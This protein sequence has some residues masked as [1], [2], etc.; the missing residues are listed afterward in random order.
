MKPSE[1]A[2]PAEG[3]KPSESAKPAEGV[4][5]SE[6][7]KPA[8]GVKPSESAKPADGAM[9]AVP[10]KQTVS[11][12]NNQ[13]VISDHQGI[14]N[15]NQ[16]V[17]NIPGRGLQRH[18]LTLTLCF[19]IENTGLN[20]YKLK[21]TFPSAVSAKIRLEVPLP[22][23]QFTTSQGVMAM[24]PVMLNEK[25]SEIT[26]NG[27]NRT[28]DPTEIIWSKKENKVSENKVVMQVEDAEIGVTPSLQ[29]AQF[30]VV[31]PVKISGGEMDTFRI[32]LPKNTQL[33]R[34]SL[35]ATG[36][37]NNVLDIRSITEKNE[38]EVKEAVNSNTINNNVVNKET[39]KTESTVPVLNI[40]TPDKGNEK[41][42]NDT[43]SIIEIHLAQKVTEPISFRF[44]AVARSPHLNIEEGKNQSFPNWELSGFEL[45]EAQKQYGRIKF[46]FPKG[47]GFKVSPLFGVRMIGIEHGDQDNDVE[48]YQF[49][50]QPFAMNI[51]VIVQQ[52]R[53][54][55]K[56]EYQIQVQQDEVRL[57]ALFR[58]TIYGSKVREL[59][60][61]IDDW[62]ISEVK[63]NYIV[64]FEKIHEE[65]IRRELI[66]PL[67]V[68]SEGQLELELF[69]V[70]K[71]QGAQKTLEFPMPVPL[72]DWIEP[73]A[74]VIVPDDNIELLPDMTKTKGIRLTSL[75]SLSIV[76]ELPSRQQQPLSFIMENRDNRKD[77]FKN[78]EFEFPM[79]ASAV[80]YHERSIE[81]KSR[82]D[83]FL[84]EKDTDKIQQT[85]TYS[86]L[87]E[88]LEA[89][90]LSIP[91]ELQEPSA[92]KVLVDGKP[93]APQN[94]V[95]DINDDPSAK[96]VRKKILLNDQPR[97]GDCVVTLLYSCRYFE[98]LPQMTNKII[99]D[100]V[101]PLDGKLLSNQVSVIAPSGINIELGAEEDKQWTF[102]EA[103]SILKGEKL[104]YYYNTDKISN[105]ITLKGIINA[106]DV[107]GSTLVEKAWIQTWLVN[108]TRMD[109]SSYRILSDQKVITLKLPPKVRKERISLLFNS[110]SSYL[111]QNLD[112][113][114]DRF[115]TATLNT[116]GEL[117]IPI[118]EEYRMKPFTLDISWLIDLEPND[119]LYDMEFPY[120]TGSSIW[121]RRTYWQV[122]LPTNKHLV[123]NMAGWT[124]EYFNKLFWSGFYWKREA[125]MNQEELASWVGVDQRESI[126]DGTNTYLFSSFRAPQN[127]ML[128]IMDRSLL[129]LIGSGLALLIGLSFIYLPLVRH[130]GIVL[131]FIIA[132]TALCSYQPSD[133][134][135]Y[136]QTSVFGIILALLT[137]LLMRIFGGA[138]T[139]VWKPVRMTEHIEYNSSLN[140]TTDK[141]NSQVKKSS[142]IEV[143]K[144]DNS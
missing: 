59:A 131:L 40:K 15:H 119:N 63:S 126:P 106:R 45:L 72:A 104:T 11:I 9:P 83:V 133:S 121:I 87:F 89:I 85:L 81:V 61:K 23:I 2:K 75:R 142:I 90:Q 76:M 116:K 139:P 122:I 111:V 86:I 47:L 100:L 1:S 16:D 143:D 113:A 37:S 77:D 44:K 128:R 22:D 118:P 64:D 33:I 28:G 26:L 66:L 138:P 88:P 96:T 30:D 110:V 62:F 32:R 98:L 4:K 55:V 39:A 71:L 134:I 109:R 65:K 127:S 130:R 24:P 92:I 120:F 144:T 12:K 70:R 17:V 123:G 27:L 69:A 129:I 14:G 94:I 5:P 58:F 135:I 13:P 52:T 78:K 43:V 67:T 38:T 107:F 68:P 132:V 74:V 60:L 42:S 73:G 84:V 8:E 36:F 103:R 20:E 53:I 136:L 49:Y 117:N 102:D 31:L 57:H 97:I 141:G 79:F 6:S 137:L 25:T 56:P 54:K 35:V 19:P 124:P 29:D 101:Q 7:A 140:N 3:V 105:Q 82:A 80:K 18:L 91:V 108:S 114:S 10:E 112:E 48:Q 95:T 99:V 34:E 41:E 93:V 46:I 125:S 115:R 21:A 50:A 51:Q